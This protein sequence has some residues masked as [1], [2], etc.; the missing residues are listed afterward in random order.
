MSEKPMALLTWG[1]IVSETAKR[2]YARERVELAKLVRSWRRDYPGKGDAI[3]I[4]YAETK[5]DLLVEIHNAA[6]PN[7]LRDLLEGKHAGRTIRIRTR[8]GPQRDSGETR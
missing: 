4:V 2:R 8:E 1:R 7:A 6:K 3:R 5:W